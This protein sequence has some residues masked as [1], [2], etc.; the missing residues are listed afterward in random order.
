M[1]PSL[2]LLV[3]DVFWPLEMETTGELINRHSKQ[4]FSYAFT[5]RKPG[6]AC[7]YKLAIDFR[8]G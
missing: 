8:K 5:S 4:S 6:Y 7:K 3:V 1:S 2:K